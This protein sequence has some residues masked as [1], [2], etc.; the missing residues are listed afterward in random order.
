MKLS[1][2]I[3]AMTALM[4][5]A[6]IAAP[7][8]SPWEQPAAALADQ[9]SG[10]LGPGQAR[11]TI[12]N[13]SSISTDDIPA[14][15]Q[16]LEQDLRVRGVTASGAESANTVRVTLSESAHD[17]LWVAE[18]VEGDQTQV[19]VVDLGPNQP[20][21]PQSAGGIMLRKDVLLSASKPLLAA[22]ELPDTLIAL[23]PEQIVIYAHAKD[24]W[25]EQQRVTIA[26]KRPLSRD[27]RGILL[28]TP[29]GSGFDAWL[30][31]MHCTGTPPAAAPADWKIHCHE[32][33]DPWAVTSPATQLSVPS[34]P[35]SPP[36][37]TTEDVRVTPIRAFYNASRNY[38]TG[39]LAPNLG[40]DLPPFYSLDMLPHSAG[41]AAVLINGIDGKVQLI[42][43]GTL[44]S[45]AG[46]RDWGSDLG[47][48]HST[49]GVGAQIVASGSGEAATDSLRAYELP[50]LEVLPVSAPL[51]MDGTVTAIWPAPDGKS[52]FAALRKTP[53]QYEVDRVT[54]LCN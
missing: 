12:R 48:L 39:I 11:L 28:L 10:I 44:H 15:R 34:T 17:R 33:D 40:P 35:N 3:T 23:E 4:G 49:C 52:V 42:E 22:L 5:L 20:Q 24:G 54:A 14:I 30:P 25:R 13:L 36:A 1:W 27:P 45:I 31:G 6:A 16:L 53:N 7:A 32:S 9:I 2:L 50:A 37:T 8:P 29:D 41:I 21:Q 51:A 47:V 46:T 43:S 18:V 26:Q 19:A 38:F